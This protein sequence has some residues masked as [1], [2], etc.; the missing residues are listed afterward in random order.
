MFDLEELENLEN[1][2]VMRAE[3]RDVAKRC[4]KAAFE[5]HD[6]TLREIEA[7]QKLMCK[8]AAE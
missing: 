3:A 7:S 4:T 6:R 2:L 1:H 8:V 5:A